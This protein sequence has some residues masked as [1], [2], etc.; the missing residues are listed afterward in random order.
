M[1]DS[2]T[3]GGSSDADNQAQNSRTQVQQDFLRNAPAIR[4]F[5]RSLQ[6]SFADAED[7]FQELFLLVSEKADTY[8]QGTN[9]LGWVYTIARYKILAHN[10]KNTRRS[11][12]L[13]SEAAEVLLKDAPHPPSDLFEAKVQTLRECIQILAPTART[14]MDLRYFEGMKPSQIAERLQIDVN[15]IYLILSRSRA[16]LRK[17]VEQQ[18]PN[19]LS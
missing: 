18:L 16:L 13:Q 8:T 19:Q 4:N 9:F 12:L 10:R 7:H 15:R 2:Q 1:N 6:P 5:L 3:T 17:C 11:R 14:I